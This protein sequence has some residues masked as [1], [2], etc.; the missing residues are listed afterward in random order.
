[1]LVKIDSIPARTDALATISQFT[2]DITAVVPIVATAVCA[3][4]LMALTRAAFHHAFVMPLPPL[5]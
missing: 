2:S 3:I 4:V 5:Q 1:M